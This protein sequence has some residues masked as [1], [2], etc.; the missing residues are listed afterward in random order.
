MELI[1]CIDANNICAPLK[2]VKIPKK[3]CINKTPPSNFNI[4]Q[5]LDN[6]SV[7]TK[8]EIKIKINNIT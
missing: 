8:K 2:I 7:I 4:L 3:I 6:F 1:W 5:N